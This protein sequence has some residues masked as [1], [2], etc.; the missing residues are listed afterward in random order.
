MMQYMI[1]VCI[2]IYM[3][4]YTYDRVAYACGLVYDISMYIIDVSRFLRQ[5]MIHVRFCMPLVPHL[6]LE[7]TMKKLVQRHEPTI[8]EPVL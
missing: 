5:S 7:S 1:L 6:R 3:H 8:V 4:I 2:Y